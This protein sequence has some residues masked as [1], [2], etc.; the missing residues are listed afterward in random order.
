MKAGIQKEKERS[1][2]RHKESEQQR[3][4]ER[5]REEIRQKRKKTKH[6]ITD[7][8]SMYGIDNDN[9]CKTHACN[10]GNNVL[11]A[12]PGLAHLSSR[13]INIIRY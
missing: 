7:N 12:R 3:E 5:E 11:V 13:W 2:R 10:N 1:K 9:T 8:L 6:K 4:K